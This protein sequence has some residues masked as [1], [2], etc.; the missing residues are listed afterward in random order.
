[1]P[2]GERR[3]GQPGGEGGAVPAAQD[4]HLHDRRA[5]PFQDGGGLAQER[6]LAVPAGG[7]EHD[8]DPGPHPG[9]QGIELLLPPG[10][11]RP[12]DGRAVV[13][14]IGQLDDLPRIGALLISILPT[15]RAIPPPCGPGWPRRR[16]ALTSGGAETAGR[17]RR[18]LEQRLD[19]GQPLCLTRQ[20]SGARTAGAAAPGAPARPSTAPTTTTSGAGRWATTSASTR[21]SAWRGSSPACRG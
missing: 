12:L 3:A 20:R 16:A 13:V 1:A 14:G 8:A 10:E 2:G 21:S 19:A 11:L 18:R 15:S 9:H 6:C 7:D 4:V 17:R 5:L